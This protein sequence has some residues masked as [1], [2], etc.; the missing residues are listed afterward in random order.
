MLFSASYEMNDVILLL[1]TKKNGHRLRDIRLE[2]F[3]KY[4]D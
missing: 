2:C 4:S 1:R 3:G